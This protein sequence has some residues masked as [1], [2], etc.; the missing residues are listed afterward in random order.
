MLHF[1]HIKSYL[2]VSR[3]L[4]KIAERLRLVFSDLNLQVEGDPL[5]ITVSMGVTSVEKCIDLDDLI[6]CV[7][8]GVY[9]AKHMGRNRVVIC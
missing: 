9:Q 1:E 4:A 5:V 2:N 6:S 3:S 7:E 8:N